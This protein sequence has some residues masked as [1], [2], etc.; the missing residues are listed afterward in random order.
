MTG[1]SAETRAM[2][3]QEGLAPRKRLGQHFLVDRNVVS[4][5][6][7]LAEVAPDEAVLEIGP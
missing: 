2:L 6:I 3:A 1:L 7:A 4:R 5:M